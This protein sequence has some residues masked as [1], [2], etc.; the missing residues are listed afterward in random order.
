MGLDLQP[1]SLTLI[2]NIQRIRRER[3]FT[4]GKGLSAYLHDKGEDTSK[5]IH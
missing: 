5:H 4:Q 3:L 2:S 1:H